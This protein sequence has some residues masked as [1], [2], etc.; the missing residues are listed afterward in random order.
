MNRKSND[1]PVN[2]SNHEYFLYAAFLSIALVFPFIRMGKEALDGG[3]FRWNHVVQAWAEILPFAILFSIHAFV[4]LP[5]LLDK[6]HPRKYALWTTTLICAFFIYNYSQHRGKGPLPPTRPVRTVPYSHPS[7]ADFPRPL[8]HKDRFDPKFDGPSNDFKIPAPVIIDTFIAILLLGCNL[9]IKLMFKHYES[10]R[11]MDELEK[12]HIRQE[13]AQLKAQIS[14]HFFMNSLNNIH[15]M[16]E[17]DPQ[18]AQEMILDLSGMMRYVLYESISAEIVLTKEIDFLHNY[19]SLMRTRYTK[20]RVA[21]RSHFPK[22]EETDSVCIPPLIFIIFIENAFK[23]GVDYRTDS[24]VN[25]DLSIR[26]S[27]LIFRSVNSCRPCQRKD[28]FGGVGL[29]NIRKRLDIL[30]GADYTLDIDGQ[31]K[32]FHV[33]L[34]IPTKK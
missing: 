30:Y 9:A 1:K 27:E 22:K 3:L 7:P 33:T 18:K 2:R 17:I 12:A 31:E 28:V 10:I 8:L 34:I 5:I 15:G 14:P 24:F 21:I 29:T 26:D 25:I 32:S 19:I 16:V 11:R 4:L 13:L 23:H 20:N 6:R